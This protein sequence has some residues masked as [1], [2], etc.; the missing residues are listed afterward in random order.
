[1]SQTWHTFKNCLVI[2]YGASVLEILLLGKTIFGRWQKSKLNWAKVKTWQNSDKTAK[3][4]QNGKILAKWQNPGKTA[5][6]WQNIKTLAKR[7]NSETSAKHLKFLKKVKHCEV[8]LLEALER[9]SHIGKS[10]YFVCGCSVVRK[11][12]EVLP[13]KI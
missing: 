12:L 7:K 2:L 4:W 3:P 6:L 8:Q 9:L 13:K 5:K 1:M 10:K 11:N